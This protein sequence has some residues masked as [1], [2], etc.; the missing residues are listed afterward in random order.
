MTFLGTSGQT[1][2]D[3]YKYV[4]G[5]DRLGMAERLLRWRLVAPTA[6]DTLCLYPRPPEMVSLLMHVIGSYPFHEKDQFVIE[7]CPHVFF[8]GNQPEY[9]TSLL[10]G[11]DGQQVR[12]VLIPKFSETGQIIVVDLDTLDVEAVKFSLRE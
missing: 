11:E 1:L 2:D 4:E 6:P 5:D 7:E 12:V 3:V 8:V 9:K 10:E